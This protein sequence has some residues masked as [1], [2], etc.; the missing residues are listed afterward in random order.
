M[1]AISGHE[2]TFMPYKSRGITRKAQDRLTILLF[3]LPAFIFIAIFQIYP[4][5]R[6]AY[7]SVWEWNGLG[8]LETYVGLKNFTDIWSDKSFWKGLQ[9]TSLIVVW[10]LTIQLP[11]ALILA[12][13]IERDLP[14]RAIFRS[15]LFV[16]F[17]LSEVIIGQI[18]IKMFRPD[19]HYGFINLILDQFGLKAQPWLGDPNQAMACAFVA[20]SWQ[21]FGLHML[22]YIAG[23][24]NVPQELE[25]AARIDGANEIQTIWNITLPMIG[26]AIRTS[27]FL[28]LLGSI[29]VFGLVWVMT[30]GGPIGASETLATYMYRAAF[31]KF[32]LGYGS[33]VAIIILVLSLV[34]STVY[35]LAAG[36]HEHV[37]GM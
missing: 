2:N 13:L 1:S 17:V 32:S 10:S 30:R 26:N 34:L 36:R 23:L 14:G 28:S 29:Q 31:L 24:Q 5:I 33:A 16:P 3:L 25:E 21:Y 35:Q 9:N 12:L 18:W 6:S 19:A 37:G 8:P 20:L 7:F 11:L 22:L 27:V 15:I 4:M